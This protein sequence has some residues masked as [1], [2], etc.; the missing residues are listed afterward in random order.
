VHTTVEIGFYNKQLGS[1]SM[2]TFKMC[3]KSFSW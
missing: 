3:P 2:N 1:S